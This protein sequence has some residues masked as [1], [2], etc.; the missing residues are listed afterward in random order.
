MA[1]N[2]ASSLPRAMQASAMRRSLRNTCPCPIPSLATRTR[3]PGTRTRLSSSVAC[4]MARRP[5]GRQGSVDQQHPVPVPGQQHRRGRTG[6]AGADHDHVEH[7]HLLADDRQAP[8]GDSLPARRVR[9]RVHMAAH[10]P[11][12][13]TTTISGLKYLDGPLYH[14][15]PRPPRPR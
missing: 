10:R 7:R 1:S 13:D 9:H 15:P 8:V 11:A 14:Q 5:I 12:E 4:P 3:W 2:R 6:A